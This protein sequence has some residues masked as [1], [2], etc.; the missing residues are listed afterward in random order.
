MGQD[1]HSQRICCESLNA[2]CVSQV[3]PLLFVHVNSSLAFFAMMIAMP[4][5]VASDTTNKQ[6]PDTKSSK[7]LTSGS[8]VFD[9][10]VDGDTMPGLDCPS[11]EEK[12]PRGKATS[13][14]LR[15][16][17]TALRYHTSWFLQYIKDVHSICQMNKTC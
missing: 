12:T 1:T 13:L 10:D 14:E 11:G 16:M 7:S 3:N 9:D 6:N 5:T 15:N 8:T 4:N 17:I 2:Q